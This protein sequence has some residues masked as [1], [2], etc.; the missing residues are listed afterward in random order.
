MFLSSED[1]C[2]SVKTVKEKVE[3]LVDCEGRKEVKWAPGILCLESVVFPYMLEMN[4]GASTR[5]A[6]ARVN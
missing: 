5:A 3:K 2:Q 4:A 6:G 1:K